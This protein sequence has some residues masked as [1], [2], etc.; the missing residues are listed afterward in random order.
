M[1]YVEYISRRPGIELNDFQDV[2]RRVQAAWESGNGADQLILNGARTWRLGPDPEYLAVWHTIDAGFSRLDDWERAFRKRGNVGDKVT[3]KRVARIDFAGCYEAIIAPQ[4]ARRGIYYVERYRP[5]GAPDATRRHFRQRAKRHRRLTL[6]L[7]IERIGRL[8]PEPGG[9]A[10]WTI[11]NFAAL[12]EIARDLDGVEEPLQL[13]A[14][15][16]YV[17]VGMEVL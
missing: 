2:V 16:L 17:D 6:N 15:G 7:V 12:D 10:A 1:I 3:M 5:N 13:T 8:G 14:A 9:L 11:P 4:P